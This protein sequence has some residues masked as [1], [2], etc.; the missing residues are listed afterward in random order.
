MR[1][2]ASSPLPPNT[3]LALKV[4]IRAI[5]W[6]FGGVITTSPFE[7]FNTLEAERGLPTDFIRGI[8]AT[9]P[10]TNAW[11]QFERSDI[12]LEE[13]STLFEQE[14]LAM[15]HAL[16]GRDVIGSLEG[17]VRPEMVEALRRCKEQYALGCITNTIRADSGLSRQRKDNGSEALRKAFD[18]FDVVIESAVVGL[19]KPDPA[20]YHMA[21]EKLDI[22]PAEAVY[23]DDLGINLKPARALG[24][25]TIKVVAADTALR[26][27]EQVLG[28]SLG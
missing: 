28:I 21:C 8:N 20:I 7:S 1:S 23:L 16:P 13:F 24:M 2:L 9:N 18:I 4:S 26:E 10:D 11:A 3:H 19:R 17:R 5:I 27:L 15:G 22:A 25:T 6:D 12:G 14:A